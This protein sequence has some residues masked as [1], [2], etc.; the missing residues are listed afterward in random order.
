M[1]GAISLFPS[2]DYEMDK[3]NADPRWEKWL[4]RLKNLFT[5]MSTGDDQDAQCHALLLHYAWER[6]YYIYNVEKGEGP[7]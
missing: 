1:G 5:A 2:F 3:A 4:A 6:V 7:W